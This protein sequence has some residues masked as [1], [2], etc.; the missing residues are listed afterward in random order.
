MRPFA[1]LHLH[2]E[3]SIQPETLLA[4]DPTLSTENALF[5]YQFEN[6]DGF[7][8]SYIRVLKL[9]QTPDHYAIAA[10]SLKNQLKQQNVDY[11]EINLSVGAMIF[12]R[13]NVPAI[14]EAVRKELGT[15]PLIFDAIR[16]HD[17]LIAIEV[18]ELAQHYGAA[19]GIGGDETAQPLSTF[20]EAISRV[21]ERFIPHAGEISSAQSVWDAVSHGARR[22]GHGIRAIDDP[23]LCRKLRDEQIPL[24]IS[25]SSNLATG[26]VRSLEEHPVRRLF[27]AGIPIVLNTDDPAI[28][29]TTLRQEYQLAQTTFGFTEEEM[30]QIRR[31][32]YQ[33]AME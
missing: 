18:A 15:W 7:L 3:G 10:R 22:I 5:F 33:F 20:R 30:E 13:R 25:I 8:Q 28:F 9:L 16:Q 11:A 24:E 4:I 31:N 1:E 2:L 17:P 26:A 32:A 12:F 29:G 6:F 21:P 19:F 14:I 23:D 27:D